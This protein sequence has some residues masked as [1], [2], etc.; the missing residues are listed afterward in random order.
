ML[1]G[2]EALRAVNWKM[3]L[4]PPQQARVDDLLL[5]SDSHREFITGS[6][7]KDSTAPGMTKS[8]VYAAYIEYCDRRGWLAMSKNRFGKLGPEVIAQEF[9]LSTRGDI[10]GPDGKQNDGWKYLRLETEKDG[11]L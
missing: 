8:E 3:H 5:E 2:L 9:G 11:S 1:D 10:A 4:N 6:L 7:I